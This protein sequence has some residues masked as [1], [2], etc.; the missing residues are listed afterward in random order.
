MRN[1]CDQALGAVCDVSQTGIGLETGQPPRVGQVVLLRI[2]LDDDIEEIRART[3]R[4]TRVGDSSFFRVGLTWD[5]DSE[6]QV[7]FLARVFHVAAALHF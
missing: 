7:M 1:E 5:P 6:E 4:V 3:T 2:C